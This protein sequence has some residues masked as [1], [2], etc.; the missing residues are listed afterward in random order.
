MVSKWQVNLPF[1]FT[2]AMSDLFQGEQHQANYNR[3][4]ELS[5]YRELFFLLWHIYLRWLQN[6]NTL[7]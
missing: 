6:D 4:F 5:P 7:P 3:I 2:K 1:T